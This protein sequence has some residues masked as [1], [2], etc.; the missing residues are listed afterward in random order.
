MRMAE[1]IISRTVMALGLKLVA[2]ENKTRRKM[3][4]SVQHIL[5]LTSKSGQEPVRQLHG[6]LVVSSCCQDHQMNPLNN[7]DYNVII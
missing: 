4:G 1:I 2:H 5:A 7:M 6:C 3:S